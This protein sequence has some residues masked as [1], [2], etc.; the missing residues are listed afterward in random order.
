MALN[1]KKVKIKRV[2]D[3]GRAVFL[4]T[5]NRDISKILMLKRNLQKRTIGKNSWGNIGGK[6]EP[7]E[8]SAEAIIREAFEEAKLKLSNNDLKLLYIKEIPNAKKNWHPIHFF[9]GASIDEHTVIKI[10]SESEQYAW[11]D[12]NHLPT[13][14]FD[15]KE[16][17]LSL[18][19]IFNR[20]INY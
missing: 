7:G 13:D 19:E 15:S 5:F 8:S 11:F 17:I 6:I 3:S 16:F 14:M 10:D 18:K 4:I 12:I 1:L 20:E 2:L 9:Y